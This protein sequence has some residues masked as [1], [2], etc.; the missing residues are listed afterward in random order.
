MTAHGILAER[1]I[2]LVVVLLV[3]TLLSA[4]GLALTLMTSTERSIA[5]GYAWSAETY[6]AAE[7]GLERTLK[8]VSVVADWSDVLGG[9]AQSTFVDGSPGPRTLGTGVQVDLR[10]ETDLLNCRHLSC[11]ADEMTASTNERPWGA[12][13]P[14]W[15]LYAHGPIAALDTSGSIDSR[16]YVAVW[17]SD[18]P[19]ESDGL[20]MIDGDETTGLNAGKGV[21][22]IRAQAY[23]PA[24]AK[25]AIEVT[26]RRT[27]SRIRMLSWREIRR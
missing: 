19:L 6:Y 1:G 18:D 9:L 27:A 22:Q 2:A 5:A 4:L 17:I 23:G 24:N 3:T 10:S 7:A 11:T 21:L 16:A 8:E 20:P 25:Q 14:V 26:I 15:R 12:N 13:N